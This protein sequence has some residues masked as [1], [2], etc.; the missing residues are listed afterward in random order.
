MV[1]VM[2][3]GAVVGSYCKDLEGGPLLGPG[4]GGEGGSTS[5]SGLCEARVRRGSCGSSEGSGS[6]LRAEAQ[7]DVWARCLARG[8][9]TSALPA[10]HFRHCPFLPAPQSTRP[11][12]P[13][14][15]PPLRS[16]RVVE[17]GE[18]ADLGG[19]GCVLAHVALHNVA[20]PRGLFGTG[21][22]CW[23]REGARIGSESRE[24]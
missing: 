4:E 8:I 10:V 15:L 7:T 1:V 16:L 6:I 2:V 14:P 17:E 23:R 9:P 13:A 5:S 12:E 21:L 22:P 11:C 3:A 18:Y 24:G 19:H 20:Q